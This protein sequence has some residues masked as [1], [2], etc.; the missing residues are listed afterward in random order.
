M[1]SYMAAKNYVLS[2]NTPDETMKNIGKTSKQNCWSDWEETKSVLLIYGWG[3]SEP[4]P[5]KITQSQQGP[6]R[7]CENQPYPAKSQ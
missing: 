6:P 1:I 7:A 3:Q 2:R 5:P 4:E